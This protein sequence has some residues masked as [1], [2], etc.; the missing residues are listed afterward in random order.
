MSEGTITWGNLEA[1]LFGG[2]SLAL[3]SP[4]A[5]APGRLPQS[6]WEKQQCASG[7]VGDVKRERTFEKSISAIYG[8]RDLEE[9]WDTYG[10]LLASEQAIQFSVRLLKKLQMQPEISQPRVSPISTGV[11]IEWRA[12]D[13]LLYFEVDED[14]VLFVREEGG[15]HRED[16]E[17]PSF[18]V[19]RAIEVVKRLHG[20]DDMSAEEIT[21]YST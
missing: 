11:Y 16:G 21:Q 9:N 18:D 3:V 14:T 10:G 6:Q 8:Y 17:D 1:G 4:E 15:S 7:V 2:G 12:G 5:S 20:V 13:R 19:A